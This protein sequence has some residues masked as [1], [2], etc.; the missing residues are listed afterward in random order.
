MK[1]DE[2]NQLHSSS[3]ELTQMKFH[4]GLCTHWKNTGG[5]REAAIHPS[6]WIL[7]VAKY[8]QQAKGTSDFCS[9]LLSSVPLCTPF[10]P[11]DLTSDPCLITSM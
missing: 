9:V 8:I 11:S 5:P 10:S 4:R 6:A 1:G 3:T 7:A 2:E